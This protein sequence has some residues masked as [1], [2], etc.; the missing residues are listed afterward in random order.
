MHCVGLIE[1]DAVYTILHLGFGVC[2]CCLSI[3][4]DR[5]PPSMLAAHIHSGRASHRPPTLYLSIGRCT[6]S[7]ILQTKR[8]TH[9]IYTSPDLEDQV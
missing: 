4:G 8:L 5:A 3:L 1:G 7:Y 9:D 6:Y 2:L